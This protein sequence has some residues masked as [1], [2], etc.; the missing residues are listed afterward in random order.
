MLMLKKIIKLL[1]IL[2]FPYKAVF[3]ADIPIIV[4]APSKKAQS[5]SIVG[6]SVT[7][8]DETFF[9][10]SNEFFLGDALASNSTSANFFQSGGQ[11]QTSAIQ[12]RGLPK[13]YSTVYIDGVKMSDPASV[14]ND[15]DF[16]HILTSQIS[17]VEILKGNQSSV[18]GSGA[19][20]GT[21]NITTKKGEPG[22]QKNIQYNNASHGTHNLSLSIS[23]A[24]ENDNFFVG[25]ER[26]QTD[27]ISAMTHNDEKDRYRNN[28]LVANYGHQFSDK[29]KFESNIR[30]AE[31]YSQYDKEV[32]TATADHSEE[33]DAVQSSSNI[34]LVYKPNS[35]FTNKLT[36]ANTYIKRIAALTPNSGNTAQDNYYGDRYA[37]VYSGNY[38]INLDNSV[39]FGLEREDDQ[40]GYNKDMTGRVNKDAYVTSSYFD[41]QSR[42]TKNIYA[43]FGSRFDEHNHAGKEDSHRATLAYLFNDKSTKLKSSYGTGF[44]FPSLYE[45]NFLNSFNSSMKAETSESFDFGIEKSFLNLGLSIDASYFNL[46]YDDALEG[47]KGPKGDWSTNNF[48]GVVKSQGLELISKWKKSETLNFG[49]NY[50]YTSTYDGAEQ[51]DP[52]KNES[53]H[54]ARMVRVPRH[55]INLATNI[56][57]PGYKNLDLTLNTKW[58]DS[59]RDYGNGNRTW[60]DETIDDYLVNDLSIKSNLWNTYNL[61]F[62]I[63]N[64]LDEKYETTRDYSQM[65]RSFNFGI[66]RVY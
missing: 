39:L 25:L 45:L 35:Q 6:T 4:I 53:Y 58:S 37:L 9:K 64:I 31:T 54:D 26:F 17:R 19:I 34:S 44:R 63:N 46:K 10:N 12:L 5:A 49:M 42:V 56:K 62:D 60:R 2:T 30:V 51:D 24:D 41:F 40:I 48:P 3:A 66:R 15:Y 21:I 7:V 47:W 59:A 43:T 50:T 65:D 18:Y 52:D 57:I 23:G 28:S 33:L 27:G 32:D 22:F 29:I 16:N 36:L 1:I 13:R 11:G 38:N 55:I 20:G 61:F 8:L 14:S